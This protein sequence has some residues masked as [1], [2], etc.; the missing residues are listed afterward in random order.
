MKSDTQKSDAL[1]HGTCEV[2]LDVAVKRGSHDNDPSNPLQLT[3]QGVGLIDAGFEALVSH[4]AQE[5][6]SLK[7]IL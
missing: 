6:P 4:F 5:Y 7:S 2:T 1:Q 3:G